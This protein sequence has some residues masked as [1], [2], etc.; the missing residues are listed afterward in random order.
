MKLIKYIASSFLFLGGLGIMG[1]G[2]I[3]PALI[4]IVLGVVLFPKINQLLKKKFKKFNIKSVRYVIYVTLFSMSGFFMNRETI[5][6]KQIEMKNNSVEIKETESEKMN[7][8]MGNDS[9]WQLYDSE[10]KIRIYKLVL[11]KDCKGLQHQF[12]I[13]DKNSKANQKR[14]GSNNAYLMDFINTKMNEIE[15]Y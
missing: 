4:L 6:Y 9:F 14:T 10:L 12:N 15:C 5:G 7:R 13:A 11:A 1:N 8:I 3:I 2:E